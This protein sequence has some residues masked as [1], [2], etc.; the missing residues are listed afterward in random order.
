MTRG[1][2]SV[3]TV[4]LVLAVVS[5]GGGGFTQEELDAAV[6]QAVEEAL[7]EEQG[8][9]EA[10]STTTEATTTT[11]VAA[12]TT[13]T[14]APV[15]TTTTSGAL[16]DTDPRNSAAIEGNGTPP[17]AVG[18]PG[19]VS[20]ISGAYIGDQTFDSTRMFFVVRNNTGGSVD[21]IEVAYTV[22]DSNAGLLAS[23]TTTNM[24]PWYV[25]PG[26]IGF[27]SGF[28][29][30]MALPSDAAVETQVSSEPSDGQAY[31]LQPSIQE[32][33]LQ[34]E[35]VVA[36]IRNDTGSSLTLASAG[37]MCF[38]EDGAISWFDTG[39]ADLDPIPVGG[40][41]PVTVGV[42]GAECPIYLISSYGFE[43]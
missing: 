22:R 27:G 33:T 26:E 12:S 10:A 40:T 23:G 37:A 4:I 41:S 31:I 24:Y 36:I 25:G 28:I 30:E 6:E 42:G 2:Q 11:S 43:D 29:R 17:L 16:D 5:C 32:H 20:V 39:F 35:N 3:G 15:E 14:L 8:E 21:A 34:G 9:V 38:L 19:A 18:E 7:A 1:G 13:T